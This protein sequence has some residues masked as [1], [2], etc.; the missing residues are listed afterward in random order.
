[1]GRTR[2]QLWAHWQELISEQ[3]RGETGVTVFCRDRGLSTASFYTWRKRLGHADGT[4][5]ESAAEQ[6]VRFLEA[7]VAA[8]AE[9]VYVPPVHGTPIE[10]RLS[11]GRSLIVGP[12][13]DAMHLRALIEVLETVV[14]IGLSSSAAIRVES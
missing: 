13:F 11:K 3:E 6:P 12:G 5:S 10:V 8:S 9:P 14:P 7:R 4:E 2:E 1:M